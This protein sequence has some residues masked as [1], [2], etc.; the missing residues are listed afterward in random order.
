M[1]TLPSRRLTGLTGVY[2]ADGS[3]SGELSYW[4]GARLGR[5]HCA[6]CDITHGLVREKDEW[7]RLAARL[8]VGFTAVHLD[9]RDPV[10]AEASRGQVPCV[11]ATF[12]DGSARVVVEKEELESCD[13]DPHRLFDL[14]TSIT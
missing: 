9:E 7:S 14:L 11:V 8:P 3:L 4:I 1:A 12:D 10:V 2:D 5:R 13:G 6:L